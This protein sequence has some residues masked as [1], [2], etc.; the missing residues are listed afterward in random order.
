VSRRA[1]L[2]DLVRRFDLNAV[3]LFGSRAGDG[4][5]V[6][7]GAPVQRPG[8]DL[9]VGVVARGH[10][11][12]R[13]LA[14]LQVAFEDLF[15]P[16]CVDLVPLAAVDALFQCR[17][18]AGHRVAAPDSTAADSWELGVMRRA[19]ARLASSEPDSRPT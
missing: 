4:L 8:S 12:W 1:A 3:Y 15:A 10:L 2:D 19:A 14:N 13:V 18:I 5:T 16:L 11:D 6:L 7:Q 9:D 17:A